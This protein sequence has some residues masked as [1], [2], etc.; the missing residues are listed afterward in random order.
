M[1]SEALLEIR[2]RSYVPPRFT[3]MGKHSPWDADY[4]LANIVSDVTVDSPYKV[5]P[6]CRF[7]VTEARNTIDDSKTILEK[8]GALLEAWLSQWSG[9][10]ETAKNFVSLAVAN[11]VCKIVDDSQ[12]CRDTVAP[13]VKTGINVGLASLGVPPEIPDIRQLREQGIR[14][15]AAEAASYALGNPA[16]LKQLPVDE[17]TREF[18]YKKLYD[19]AL[20]VLSKELNKVIPSPNFN[21]PEP[22]DLG[23]LEP[24]YAPHNA[25]VYIEVRIKPAEYSKYLHFLAVNPG[26]KWTSLYLHDLNH[27][28]ASVVG[29]E[30]PTFIP[31][32]GIIIPIELKPYDVAENNAD[33]A[34]AQIPGIEISRKWLQGKFGISAAD[35][36]VKAQLN[37]KP[38]VD[39]SY[40]FSDW[41]LFYE[42]SQK[43]RFRLLMPVGSKGVLDW[44]TDWTASVGVVRDADV[45]YLSVTKSGQLQNYF[46]RIDPA[47][48]CDG[49]APVVYSK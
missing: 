6:G 46:G 13:L 29:I 36:L 40:G 24:A 38:R 25:H 34:A 27:V 32:D 3:V 21:L 14:Y 7:N 33:I 18:L 8:A 19:T 16:I 37:Y 48:R 9:G 11:E 1:V 26:H 4:H 49:K 35:G 10:V 20:G 2:I 45:G 17:K 39:G 28:Y 12:S 30:V 22:R 42:T 47:P 5:W 44:A 15:V 41:D 31:A 23:P 43:A